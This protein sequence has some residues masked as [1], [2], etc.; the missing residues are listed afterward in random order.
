MERV[1]HST[2]VIE[3]SYPA[4]PE[5]VFAAFSD[6]AKRRRWNAGHDSMDVEEFRMDFRIGGSDRVRYRFKEGTPFPGAVLANDIAY[7]D[8]VVNRRI[9]F[10]Y[11]MTLGDRRFSVSLATFELLPAGGG[12]D[13]IFTEQG[14]YF[15]GADGAQMRE[16]GWRKLLDQLAGELASQI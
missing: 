10:A 1:T 3:R 13:L 7:Q 4:P 2:F 15:E 8:I 12:T 16:G 5:R 14:A 11:A 6:P 9:V